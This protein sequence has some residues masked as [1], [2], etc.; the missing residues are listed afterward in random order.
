MAGFLSCSGFY[1]AF[2]KYEK[3]EDEEFEP[4][5]FDMLEGNLFIL[6]VILFVFSIILW[7]TKKI[8]PKKMHLAVLRTIAFTIG[9]I[10]LLPICFLWLLAL[11]PGVMVK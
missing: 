11:N 7:I 3:N 9:V 6:S 8:F 1:C 10:F 4:S 5:D 2:K